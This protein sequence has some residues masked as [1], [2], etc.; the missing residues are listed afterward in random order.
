MERSRNIQADASAKIKDLER[1]RGEDLRLEEER[2]KRELRESRESAAKEREAVDKARTAA[3]SAA[4]PSTGAGVGGTLLDSVIVQES[5][6]RHYGANG[7]LLRSSAGAR[8]IAQ[9]MPATGRNPGYG[10]RPLQDDSEAEHRRFA[11]DYLGAMLR[12]FDGDKSKALAAYNA[13]PG[14]VQKAVRRYGDQWLRHMPAETQNYVP[15][16]LERE[17]RSQG[18]PLPS[19]AQ[20]REQAR[21]EPLAYNDLSGQMQVHL[22]LSAEARRLLQAPITPLS[23][24][25][26]PA[27]PF[28]MLA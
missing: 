13:G 1:R 21:R 22:D 2:Y 20:T 24:R 6:G 3:A 23:T 25:V 7:Q 9:I 15:D 26:G 10:V 16:V 5:R 11:S 18:T 12:E 27:R 19:E 4:L 28:G 8:G 14:A 17:R